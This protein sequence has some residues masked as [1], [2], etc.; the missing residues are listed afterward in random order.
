MQETAVSSLVKLLKNRCPL[1]SVNALPPR[2]CSSYVFAQCSPKTSTIRKLKAATNST[3]KYSEQR[4][5]LSARERDLLSKLPR[6]TNFSLA[7]VSRLR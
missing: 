6:E 2:V 1:R 3:H 7:A 4:H 5:K